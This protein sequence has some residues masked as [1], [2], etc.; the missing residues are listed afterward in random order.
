MNPSTTHH[1]HHDED[2]WGASADR[3]EQE[4][5]TL[6]PYVAEVA[7][8][9]DEACR[10]LHIGIRRI[11]D[12]GSGPGVITCE[13]A[14]RFTEAEVVA[15]DASP[16][17]LERVTARAKAA[18]LANRVTTHHADLHHGLGDL[19]RADL[20][21]A[22]M[23]MHHIGN[24]IAG[25]RTLHATLNPG[26]LLVLS[27]HG[28]PSR[29]LPGDDELFERLDAAGAAWRLAEIRAN[30]PD[31][32]PSQDYPTM[33]RA[34]GFSILV[35]RVV[36]VP[37]DAPLTPALRRIALSQLQRLYELCGAQLTDG[38][39]AALRELIDETHSSG[40]MNRADACLDI[41]RHVYIARAAD[42]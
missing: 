2:E 37:Y 29:Y 3:L 1:H 31:S 34:A 25:L 9:V 15:V 6:L 27:E 7:A 13:L 17:L 10:Q 40:I 21:W 42:E 32:T 14:R 4:A 28:D 26:G 16:V 33:L 22:A 20:I 23:V 19:G 11:F 18:G 30:L 36:H 38:D 35:D 8:L 12:V 24:E 5:E 39:A 41:S